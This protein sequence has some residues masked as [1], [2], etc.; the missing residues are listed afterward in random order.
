MAKQARV[1]VI[2]AVPARP[3]VPPSDTMKKSLARAAV[4]VKEIKAAASSKPS[5]RAARAG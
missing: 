3:A 2:G 5:R 4:H 1:R